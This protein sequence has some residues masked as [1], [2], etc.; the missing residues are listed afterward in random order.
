MA[1]PAEVVLSD[2]RGSA[3][4]ITIDRPDR[5]NALNAAVIDGILRGLERSRADPGVRAVVLTGSGDRAFCSGADLTGPLMEPGSRA[6]EGHG[7]GD[8]AD[9]ILA[10]G[11][12]PQPVVARVNGVALAGGLGLMLACDLVVAADD[13]EVGTP[14]VGLGLWPFLIS[15]VIQRNVPRKVALDMMMTGR[16][17]S[18]AD[19]ERWGMVNRLVP[20]RDLDR[21]VDELIDDLASKSPAAIRLGK[22]AFFR[23]QDMA[24]EE[25]LAYL[26]GMLA[27]GLQTEDMAE[28]VRAFLE[29]R[30][31]KW[32]GR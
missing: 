20:R 22:E 25:A 11:E 6:K 29:K 18:A 7:P 14:E 10:I 15:A 8:L 32:T 17:V 26:S 19:A 4:W 31:P 28:G 13:V 23:A 24:L 9:L 27:R 30:K 21:A 12:H 5:R 2:T 3:A 1:G 16:R